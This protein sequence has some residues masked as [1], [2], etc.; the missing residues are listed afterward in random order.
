MKMGGGT[1]RETRGEMTRKTCVERWKIL[2]SLKV[3]G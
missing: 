1:A 2:R 3:S